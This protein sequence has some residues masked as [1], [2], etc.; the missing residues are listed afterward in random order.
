MDIKILL[1]S[2]M[3]NPQY[4]NGGVDHIAGFLRWKGYS[5]DIAYFH[6]DNSLEDIKSHI[7]YDYEYYGFSVDI[8]NVDRCM[9]LAN[10]IK[11]KTNAKI[12]FGGAYVSCCYKN[13][14]ED[15]SGVDYVVLGGGEDPLLY[16]LTH[17]DGTELDGHP[18]IATRTSLEN[19]S[20]HENKRFDYP[21]AE[22]YFSR[23]PARKGFYTYCLQ[24]KNNTCAGACS[25]CINWSLKRKRMD[26]HYRT[27]TSIVDEMFLMYN[28]YQIRHFFFIDDDLLDPGT[29]EAKDRICDLC[30][31]IIDSGMEIT[32]TGY[33]KA[34]SISQCE[35]DEV[36]LALMYRAG[37]V[38]L[39]VGIESGC[40]KDLT[41]FRKLATIED[42]KRSLSLLY[43][44]HIKPEYEM[45][46]F[47]PYATVDSLKENFLFLK[48][49]Q[50]YNY[51]HYSITGVSIYQNTVLWKEALRD[52]LL[53]EEYSYKEPDMYRYLNSDVERLAEFVKT[54]FE[55]NKE[56]GK[57]VTADQ[58]VTYFY[59]FSRYSESVGAMKDSINK[60]RQ[61]S[62]ALLQDYF[63]P[64]YL[65]NDLETCE[66]KYDSFIKEYKNQSE[67]VQKLVNKMLKYS[68]LEAK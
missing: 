63:A 44:H 38:S 42:N 2:I 59:R 64:L 50:S 40:Q 11:E 29:R 55:M 26:F 51:R 15:C 45:I 36:L 8:K 32:I 58:L 17:N 60:V 37:F 13:L 65:D 23:Y 4:S 12:W 41:L 30:R 47:H 43:K 35:E 19:K 10:L 27:T 16:L 1:I 21:I 20:F 49:V 34:N 46:T 66:R 53:M 56:I 48:E 68:I 39:F 7:T 52:G 22:D 3:L 67:E 28:K 25:F 54:H 14:F 24:S 5:V 31:A 62:F 61:E 9:S 33:I 18:H 57:L 6:N